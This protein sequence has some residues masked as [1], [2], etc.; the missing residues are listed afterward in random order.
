MGLLG[1][2][3]IRE[4]LD[5]FF[6]DKLT[7]A[8]KEI[9]SDFTGDQIGLFGLPGLLKDIREIKEGRRKQPSSV[10]DLRCSK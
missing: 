1:E 2:D 9:I 10:Y 8:E 4:Q 5:E 3:T 6:G 7:D